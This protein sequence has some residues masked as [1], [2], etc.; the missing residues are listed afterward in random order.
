MAL[1]RIVIDLDD[2]GPLTN[3]FGLAIT[4][5]NG[6]EDFENLSATEVYNRFTEAAQRA[7]ESL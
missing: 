5:E 6:R 3:R 2:S 4:D 7:I 1:R